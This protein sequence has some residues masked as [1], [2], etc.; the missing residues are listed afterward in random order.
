[1]AVTRPSACWTVPWRR[2]AGEDAFFAGLGL[3]EFT[4]IRSVRSTYWTLFAVM[5]VCAGFGALF[6]WGR[7]SP[8]ARRLRNSP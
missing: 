1:M 8:E 3:S 5:I 6:S 2:A 7:R 4:K